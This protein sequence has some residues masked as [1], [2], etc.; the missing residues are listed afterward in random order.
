MC[1]HFLWALAE[2]GQSGLETH[3]ER[4]GLVALRRE[5]NGQPPGPLC[6]VIRYTAGVIFL[7]QSTPL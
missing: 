1:S 3:E 4:L 2:G 7:R 6:W 5:V